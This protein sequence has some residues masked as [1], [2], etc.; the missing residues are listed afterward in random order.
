VSGYFTQSIQTLGNL[1]YVEFFGQEIKFQFL[2]DFGPWSC[3]FT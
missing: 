1:K 3:S 2:K